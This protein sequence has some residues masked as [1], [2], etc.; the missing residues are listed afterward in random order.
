MPISYS[1][2]PG[3]RCPTCSES[4]YARIGNE[5]RC[6]RCQPINPSTNETADEYLEAR[7]ERGII[8]WCPAVPPDRPTTPTVW[9]YVASDLDWLEVEPS[10][11]VAEI[12][13]HGPLWGPRGYGHPA[14]QWYRR[15][16]RELFAWFVAK[17]E[18]VRKQYFAEDAE[19]VFGELRAIAGRAVNAGIFGPSFADELRWPR[20]TTGFE[21]FAALPDLAQIQFTG[22]PRSPAAAKVSNPF[23]GMGKKK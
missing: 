5:L 3:R 12:V 2:L 23:A 21:P 19:E 13:H 4:L 17:A 22:P 6:C 16:D 1:G 9:L 8:R 20:A 7:M 10:D 15:L 18:I 11:Q 14:G